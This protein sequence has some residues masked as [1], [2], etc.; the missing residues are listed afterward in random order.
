MVI[1]RVWSLTHPFDPYHTPEWSLNPY[2]R[3]YLLFKQISLLFDDHLGIALTHALAKDNLLPMSASW[4]NQLDASLYPSSAMILFCFLTSLVLLGELIESEDGDITV[5]GSHMAF[6]SIIQT[7]NF[8]FQVSFAIPILLKI[9]CIC[10]MAYRA[11]S[12][13]GWYLESAS[14]PLGIIAFSWLALTALLELLPMKFPVTASNMNYTVRTHTVCIQNTPLYH[15]QPT[16]ILTHTLSSHT[17][18]NYNSC[19][20]PFSHSPTSYY[21]HDQVVIVA[22]VMLLGELNWEFNCRYHFRGPK[23]SDDDVDY[24]FYSRRMSTTY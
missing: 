7:C 6:F 14:F 9:T 23:R 15:K 5:G 10:P 3:P 1:Y 16:L 8:A 19:L 13:S 4:F 11:L 2:N 12:K 21:T 18:L 24:G 20:L 22:F 17:I